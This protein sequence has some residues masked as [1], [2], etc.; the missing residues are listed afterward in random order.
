M[1]KYKVS[2]P[3]RLFTFVVSVGFVAIGAI[4]VMAIASGNSDG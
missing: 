1:E 4:G 3:M 2:D